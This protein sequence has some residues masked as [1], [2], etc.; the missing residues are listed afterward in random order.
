VYEGEYERNKPMLWAMLLNGALPIFGGNAVK[1][2]QVADA[3]LA[4]FEKRFPVIK[5]DDR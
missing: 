3:A 4:E 5:D 2:A 1:A